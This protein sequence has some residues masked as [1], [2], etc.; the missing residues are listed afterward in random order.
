MGRVST[1]D[2]AF[3]LF[4]V[5]VAAVALYLI[6]DLPMGTAARMGPGYVPRALAVLIALIGAFIAA[7][8]FVTAGDAFPAIA[9]RPILL[10]GAAVGLFGLLLPRLGLA[11]TAFIVVLV[12]GLAAT[13]MRWKELILIAVGLSVFAVLLFVKALG[14]PM[15]IWPV[16]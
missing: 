15:P 2:L 4:L 3:G 16:P 1:A 14:L 7:R 6:A 13:D 8:A 11:A 10:V 12:A 5:A 9:W